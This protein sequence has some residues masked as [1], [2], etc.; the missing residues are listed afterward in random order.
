MQPPD[1]TH[2]NCT[3]LQLHPPTIA[4]TTIAPTTTAPTYNCTRLQLHPPVDTK[5]WPVFSFSFSANEKPSFLS[6]DLLGQPEAS[7]LY[8]GSIPKVFKKLGKVV[9]LHFFI[10]AL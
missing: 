5:I 10:R 7:N 2:F 1:C 8:K 6:H 3:H 9:F 4:P